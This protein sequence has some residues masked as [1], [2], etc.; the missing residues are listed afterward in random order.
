MNSALYNDSG[1][2]LKEL[3][4]SLTDATEV[5]LALTVVH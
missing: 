1:V 3:I 5:A 4:V 2:T